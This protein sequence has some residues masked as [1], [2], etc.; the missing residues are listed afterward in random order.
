MLSKKASGHP[1]AGP[2]YANQSSIVLHMRWN[3]GTTTKDNTGA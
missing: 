3:H 1:M 2:Q